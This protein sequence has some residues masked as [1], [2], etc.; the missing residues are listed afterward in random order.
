MHACRFI[1]LFFND[2]KFI[3]KL[4]QYKRN[5]QDNLHAKK[6]PE[7]PKPQRNQRD[8]NNSYEKATSGQFN[9]IT[10]KEKYLDR[11]ITQHTLSII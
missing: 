3:K 2:N 7:H 1:T 5:V 11:F 8:T 4:E 9:R 6:K 10:S